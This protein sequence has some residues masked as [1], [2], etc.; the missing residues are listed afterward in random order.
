MLDTPLSHMSTSVRLL[1]LVSSTI[2]FKDLDIFCKGNKKGQPKC[3]LCETVTALEQLQK[4]I[5]LVHLSQLSW[6]THI[7]VKHTQVARFYLAD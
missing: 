4:V 6:L 2:F 7:T 3:S 1:S 5:V